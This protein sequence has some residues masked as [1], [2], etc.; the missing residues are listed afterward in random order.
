MTIHKTLHP[1]IGVERLRQEK[2]EEEAILVLPL[3]VVN[4]GFYAVA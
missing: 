3:Y 2:K 1:R 4:F